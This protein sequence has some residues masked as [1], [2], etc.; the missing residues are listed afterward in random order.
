MRPALAFVATFGSV[1]ALASGCP[2]EAP[3]TA[4]Q[5]TLCTPGDNIFCRC[6]GGSAGTKECSADGM[7]FGECEQAWGPCGTDQGGGGVGGSGGVGQGGT[8]GAGAVGGGVGAAAGT[9][10]SGGTATGG[11]GGA[12]SCHLVVNEVQ[13]GSSTAAS[14]EFVEL[15]NTCPGSI[16]LAGWKLAYRS[17]SGTSDFTLLS[18][19]S[20]AIAGQGYLLIV[21]AGWSGGPADATFANG[22]LAAAGGGVGLRDPSS[23]LVDSMGYG[24]ATN[25]LV[26]DS[27]TVAP[28]A[29]ESVARRPNGVDTN[30]NGADFVL[31]AAPTP[32]ASND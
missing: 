8:A 22:G 4:A 11:S 26:E 15:L 21:G 13:T 30:H 14:D 27:P 10:G 6:P 28:P 18:W 20:G 3:S 29:G 2:S 25:E 32:G 23:Q 9:G 17:A 19:G 16:D 24:T 12:P 7:S 31:V 5:P 1:A